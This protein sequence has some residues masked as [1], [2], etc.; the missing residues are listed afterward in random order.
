MIFIDTHS[1]L[2]T[3]EFDSDRDEVIKNAFQ[4]N[5]EKIILPNIDE[6]SIEKVISLADTYPNNCFPLIGLHPTSVN[7]SYRVQLNNIVAWID[8]RKFF[9]I[10]ETGIDLYWEKTFLTEQTD[11]FAFHLEL[12]IT[13]K[14]PVIIHVRNSFREV[15]NV[16]KKYEHPDLKGIFHCFS[17]SINEA[18]EIIDLG[19]KL[20]IGGVLTFK[21]SKL[22]EVV[23][24]INLNH[25]VLETDSPYLAPAP[26]RG[27]RNESANII[28]IAK[29]LAAI[30]GIDIAKVASQT[31]NNAIELFPDISQTI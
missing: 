10:G 25:I 19:F 22:S 26:L 5:V 30:K 15:I 14:L 2:F 8:K 9:G 31:S 17:G 23:K 11:S 1:H 13:K 21:N 6:D 4:N 3:E 16:V 18:H 7:H 12:A 24:D 29:K 27:K 28:Y 20:G